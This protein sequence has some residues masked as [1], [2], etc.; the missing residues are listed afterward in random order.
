MSFGGPIDSMIYQHK[1]N[2]RLL[3]ERKKLK[4][5]QSGYKTEKRPPIT[6]QEPQSGEFSKFKQRLKLSQKKDQNRMIL[7]IGLTLIIM[8]II[9][10]WVVTSDYSGI[11]D[12]IE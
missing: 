7:I 5:I 9:L 6:F 2:L 3:K 1:S 12:V 4:E 10:F 11:I 8:L